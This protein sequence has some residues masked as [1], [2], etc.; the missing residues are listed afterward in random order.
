MP[1]EP[2]IPRPLAEPELDLVYALD[3]IAFVSDPYSPELIGMTR[4][5]HEIERVIGTFDGD[6]LVASACI[7]SF[8]MS[9]PGGRIPM[10]GVSWVSVLPTH[11]RRGLQFVRECLLE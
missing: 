4:D 7:F 2:L 5:T 1:S 9:V 10:A 6:E 11:R 3:E 8:E